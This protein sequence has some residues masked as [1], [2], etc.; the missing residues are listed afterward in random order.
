MLEAKHRYVKMQ[1][2]PTNDCIYEFQDFMISDGLIVLRRIL[3]SNGILLHNLNSTK[4]QNYKK[5][6]YDRFCDEWMFLD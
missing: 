4:S 3:D 6:F 1:N 2:D 5:M